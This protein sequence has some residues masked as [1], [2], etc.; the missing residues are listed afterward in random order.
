MSFCRA[1]KSGDKDDMP[2]ESRTQRNSADPE[3]RRQGK[4]SLRC[5][6]YLDR[7]GLPNEREGEMY[8]IPDGK[9]RKKIVPMIERVCMALT[10][11]A[12]ETEVAQMLGTAA[13]ESALRERVQ[14]NGGP[15][16]GLWQMESGTGFDI[17]Y[18]YLEWR[19]DLAY[20]LIRL[21]LEVANA[22]TFWIPSVKD[23]SRHLELCDDFACAMAR[24]H[25]LRDPDPIPHCRELQAEYW[26]R[27]YNTPQGAG[28][29]EHYLS[30]WDAC[31]CTAL[32]DAHF[33]GSHET[34]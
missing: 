28:T 8:R 3:R 34:S 13:A 6:S 21:W 12:N 17:F 16:R 23:I 5:V 32:M 14:G 20:K 2:R 33:G 15:A 30:Q 26:K 10:G 19:H 9:V 24:I 31:E 25:Y 29:V 27:V 1:R 4:G 22:P 11:H 7:V 18:N